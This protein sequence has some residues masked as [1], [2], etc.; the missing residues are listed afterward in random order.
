MSSNF[1]HLRDAL[2]S[3]TL[4]A[5]VHT[6]VPAFPTLPTRQLVQPLKCAVQIVLMVMMVTVQTISTV[7][8]AQGLPTNSVD[9]EPPTIEME[10]TQAGI[11][12]EAQVFTAFVQD[13]IGLRD[14]KLYYRY[15]GQQPFRNIPMEP[16]SDSGY[17]SSTIPT[18]SSEIRALEYYVQA[19]DQNGNRVVRGYAFDPLV[20]SLSPAIAGTEAAPEPVIRTATT[21]EPEASGGGI[22]W[23]HIALGVL[24]AGALAGL[25]GGGS[26]GGGNN[27]G[28]T[29]VPVT[30]TV[31]P[32]TN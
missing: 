2:T 21:A 10:E 28:G 29:G 20:R 31:N 32:P 23:W 22:K 11:A 3:A 4:R 8:M 5:T 19:R 9:I 13:N 6:I 1:A 17:F 24:A 25:A 7:A 15:S 16:L 30:L 27:S 18:S 12:G 26:D 14:V